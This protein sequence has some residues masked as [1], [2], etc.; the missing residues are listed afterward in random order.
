MIADTAVIFNGATFTTTT[1][2]HNGNATISQLHV[3]INDCR[4]CRDIQRLHVY[5]DDTTTQRKHDD[6][7]SSIAKCAA[8]LRSIE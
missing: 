1:Q 5:H 3:E 7:L 8:A 6:F 2:R 4:H